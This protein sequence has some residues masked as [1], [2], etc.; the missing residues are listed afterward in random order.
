LKEI[1]ADAQAQR[2]SGRYGARKEE[3]AATW[4]GREAKMAA[5]IDARI[6]EYREMCRATRQWEKG[7]TNMEVR[8][9]Y[10]T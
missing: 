4:K 2:D 6:L 9:F 3:T 8:S 10:E 7:N 5:E 1:S